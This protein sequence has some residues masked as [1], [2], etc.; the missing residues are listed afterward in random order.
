MRWWTGKFSWAVHVPTD[1]GEKL[2][3]QDGG[4][5]KWCLWQWCL[6]GLDGRIGLPGCQ[7]TNTVTLGQWAV[8]RSG[9]DFAANFFVINLVLYCDFRSTNR[10]IARLCPLREVYHWPVLSQQLIGR[11]PP[12]CVSCHRGHSYKVYITTSSHDFSCVH[13]LHT[14][15]LS[16]VSSLQI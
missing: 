7:M 3:K 11:L 15:L 6:C 16:G 13:S 10:K 14:V 9:G 8:Y 1:R 2:Q 4:D 12:Y 5:S